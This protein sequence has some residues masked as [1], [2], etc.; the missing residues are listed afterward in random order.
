MLR[1][2][3]RGTRRLAQS[4]D[5]DEIVKPGF[6]TAM[7][8]LA[9]ETRTLFGVRCRFACARDVNPGAKVCLAFYRIFREAAHNA[10]RHGNAKVIRARADLRGG[11]LRL[12]VADDG[13]GF[14]PAVEECQGMGLRL[15]KY[16]AREIGGH[17]RITSAPGNGTCVE[18]A[19]QGGE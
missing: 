10:I 5:C 7:R 15:M 8:N 18:C 12:R 11:E 14:D 17:L 6:S 13:T 19:V 2:A 1:G 9:A 16:R 4:Q 3:V